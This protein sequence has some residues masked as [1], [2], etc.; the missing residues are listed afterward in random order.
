MFFLAGLG[1]IEFAA[2]GKTYAVYGGIFI[3]IS[4]AWAW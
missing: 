2:F 3:L 4:I 1:A